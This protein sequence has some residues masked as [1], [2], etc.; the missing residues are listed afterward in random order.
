MQFASDNGRD[1]EPVGYAANN[2]V[3]ALERD[4]IATIRTLIRQVGFISSLVCRNQHSIYRFDRL[5]FAVN[6]SL[7]SSRLSS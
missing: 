3:D 5:P 4:P 6:I 1:F 7:K 2:F